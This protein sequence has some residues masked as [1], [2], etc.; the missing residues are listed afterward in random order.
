[1]SSPQENI[2]Y[3]QKQIHFDNDLPKKVKLAFSKVEVKILRTHL[4]PCKESLACFSCRTK[5]QP[6]TPYCFQRING[7]PQINVPCTENIQKKILNKE[8]CWEALLVRGCCLP[9]LD[10]SRRASLL[11]AEV[12]CSLP[13]FI[14]R[15]CLGPYA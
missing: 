10:R 7:D 4:S 6:G 9:C 8:I 15:L 5:R 12:S 13:D 14:W 11:P 1:M 3:E 2:I